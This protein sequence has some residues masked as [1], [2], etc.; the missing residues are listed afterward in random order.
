MKKMKFTFMLFLA[1][2]A[3]TSCSSDDDGATSSVSAEDL[4]G[5]WQLTNVAIDGE[6]EELDSCELMGT[7]TIT[8]ASITTEESSVSIFDSSECTSQSSSFDYSIEGNA[9]INNNTTETGDSPIELVGDLGGFGDL[10]DGLDTQFSQTTE[11][12]SVTETTLVIRE[13]VTFAGETSTETST[14]TK[15]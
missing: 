14:Y 1:T 13:S 6:N 8:E 10:L 4:L 15:I 11:V 9:I 2:L 5:T 12:I 3:I 7:I